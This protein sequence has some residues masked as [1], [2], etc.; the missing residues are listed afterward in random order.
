M[1]VSFYSGSGGSPQGS[2]VSARSGLNGYASDVRRALGTDWRNLELDRRNGSPYLTFDLQRSMQAIP[3][4]KT[5]DDA[6][7]VHK[8]PLPTSTGERH[9]QDERICTDVLEEQNR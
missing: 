9:R 5:A 7:N 8:E 1:S 4:T 6:A 2:C 3:G